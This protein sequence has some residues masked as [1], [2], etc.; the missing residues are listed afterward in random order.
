MIQGYSSFKLFDGTDISLLKYLV[1]YFGTD[2]SL[3]KYLVPYFDNCHVHALKVGKR[4]K[5]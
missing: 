3:L 2:I 4:R 5:G 1:P